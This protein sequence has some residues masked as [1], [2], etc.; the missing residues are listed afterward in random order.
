M[1]IVVIGG[2]IAGL[3]AAYWCRELAVE[4]DIA[5]EVMLLERSARVGGCIETRSEGGFIMEMGPDSLLAEKPGAIELIRR[6][7]IEEHIIPTRAEYRGALVVRNGRLVPIPDGFRLFTPTSMRSLILGGIFSPGGMLRAAIEPLIP[8][9][10]TDEDESLASFVT[11]RFGKEVLERLAQPL[12]G[13]IYSGDPQRLS[14][15]ATMPRLRAMERT[16]GSLIRGMRRAARSSGALHAQGPLVSLRAGLATLPAAIEREL[17]GVV[18]TSSEVV[19]LERVPRACGD[20]WNI[21]LADETRIAADAVVCAL[22]AYAAARLLANVDAGVTDLLRSVRYHSVATV[23]TAYNA[24]TIPALPRATGFVVPTGEKR[25]ILA[26]TFSSQ[27]YEY[28][29]PDDGV[30]LRSFV[31]GAMHGDRTAWGDSRLIE[32]ARGELR[33]LLGIE[34]AP[35]FSVVRRWSA[36]LP[37]YE[38][39][40]VELVKAIDDRIASIPG[41]AVAGSAYGGVGIPDCIDSGRNAARSLFSTS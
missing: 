13:G 6:L 36:A 32:A 23:T 12:V 40:H 31:G 29:A 9:K 10:L 8:P 11:R 26:A 7:G 18:R 37:A 2:G 28:R 34:V 30:L 15:A 35:R 1:R 4:R 5:V 33:E 24:A 17:R 38:L 39:G 41:L 19:R 20:T 22:P 16:H 3:A 14:M 27:K 21:L 25:S